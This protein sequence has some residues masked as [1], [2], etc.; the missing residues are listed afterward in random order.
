MSDSSE[1]ESSSELPA[2]TILSEK[3][4][5]YTHMEVDV[6]DEVR[7]ILIKLGRDII[8]DDDLFQL[9]FI[10]ALK[11]GIKYVDDSNKKLLPKATDKDVG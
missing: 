4:I 5:S 7:D 6:S 11:E 9:G 3:D 2:I 1:P 10:H 8:S